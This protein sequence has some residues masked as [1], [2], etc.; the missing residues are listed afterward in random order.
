MADQG[1][2]IARLKGLKGRPQIK[3]SG[4]EPAT[5]PK[6]TGK[7]AKQRG[8]VVP[9]VSIEEQVV[10]AEVPA[11]SRFKGYELKHVLSELL[12]ADIAGAVNVHDRLY[13]GCQALKPGRDQGPPEPLSRAISSSSSMAW[14]VNSAITGCG[15]QLR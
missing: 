12:S 1:D 11:G 7:R 5:S 3:P 9:R 2:E 4:M 8:K 14:S 13:V 15:H 10:H 6:P